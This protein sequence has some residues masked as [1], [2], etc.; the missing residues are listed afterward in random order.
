LAEALLRQTLA[1]Q[2]DA[3]AEAESLGAHTLAGARSMK[4]WLSR[5]LN[6]DEAEAKTCTLV[7]QK[8][9]AQEPASDEPVSPQLHTTAEALHAGEITV[10][11]AVPLPMA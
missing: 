4:T 6:I 5:L 1:E 9:T 7:A 3:I 2:L 8:T 10:S 11:H